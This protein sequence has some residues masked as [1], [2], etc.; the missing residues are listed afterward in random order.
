VKVEVDD[1]V[2]FGMYNVS[3]T[4]MARQLSDSVQPTILLITA[5][6]DPEVGI[7]KFTHCLLLTK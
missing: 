4:Q 5:T 6:R 7:E 3:N 1:D 2:G